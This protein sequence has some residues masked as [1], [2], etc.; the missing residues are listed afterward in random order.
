MQLAGEGKGPAR[1]RILKK[2]KWY[3]ERP[4]T[5]PGI[6]ERWVWKQKSFPLWRMLE[7]PSI[8][9]KFWRLL[10]V[11]TGAGLP[12]TSQEPPPW[13]EGATLHFACPT[14]LS[15]P[16]HPAPPTHTV[17]RLLHVGA[18]CA[19]QPSQRGFHLPLAPRTGGGPHR[20]CRDPCTPAPCPGLCQSHSPL[21]FAPRAQDALERQ[22]SW[23]PGITGS[24]SYHL[25]GSL[26][27][28]TMFTWWSAQ[29]LMLQLKA[30]NHIFLLDGWN[31]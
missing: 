7:A 5:N 28:G 1:A 8:Y 30:V 15:P 16:L 13:E 2:L 27:W 25:L 18:T 4:P 10:G 20:P 17:L 12:R 9:C 6:Y 14:P 26:Y 24:S 23:A 21:A 31:L 11:G 22:S 29:F 3:R 19:L